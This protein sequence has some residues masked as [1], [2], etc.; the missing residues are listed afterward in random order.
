LDQPEKFSESFAKHG[1]NEHDFQIANCSFTIY[2]KVI[3]LK[4]RRKG[5]FESVTSGS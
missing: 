4:E 1:H 5:K 2:I 3:D